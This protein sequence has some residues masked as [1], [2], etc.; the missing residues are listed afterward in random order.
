MHCLGES[1]QPLPARHSK[2]DQKSA[3]LPKGHGRL[4]DRKPAAG[5]GPIEKGLS[6][7]RPFGLA[8]RELESEGC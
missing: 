8:K 2:R 6:E 7:E 5:L 1:A 4:T 3:D